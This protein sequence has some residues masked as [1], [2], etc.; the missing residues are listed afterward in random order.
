MRP[1]GAGDLRHRLKV[2][3]V[4]EI[5]KGKGGYTSDW[6]D[7]A[8]VAAAVESLD[9]REVVMDQ[10]LQGIST[11]RIRIRWRA[12]LKTEDQLRSSD[13][14]FGYD[15]QGKARDVNIRSAVDP[16]GLRRQL[17]IM[18]DTASTRS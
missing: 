6:G 3:R 4:T 13:G 8:D 15:V 11:F 18:A 14:C 10:A 1:L 2:R 7:Y 16:D 17:V 5:P 9:G 12:D